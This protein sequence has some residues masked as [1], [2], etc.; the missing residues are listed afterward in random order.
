MTDSYFLNSLGGYAPEMLFVSCAVS[1]G[2]YFLKKTLLKKYQNAPVVTLLPFIL[3][4]VFYALYDCIVHLTLQGFL[5][6]AGVVVQNGFT[7][8]ALSAVVTSLLDKLFGKTKLTGKALLIRTL[9]QGFVP[10]ELLDDL[11]EKI[12]DGLSASDDLDETAVEKVLL[13]SFPTEQKP[14]EEEIKALARLLIF[15]LKQTT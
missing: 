12:A 15:T 8:G 10:N 5:S 2:C 4:I 14:S 6:E 11:A 1:F 7:T 13:E 9:L 3:G